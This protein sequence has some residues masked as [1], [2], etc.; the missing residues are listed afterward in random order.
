MAYVSISVEGGMFPSDLLDRMAAGADGLDG[1]RA[2]DFGLPRGARLTEEMQAAFAEMRQLRDMFHRRQSRATENLTT[3]TRRRWI[4]PLLDTL[5]YNELQVQRSNLTAGPKTFTISHLAAEDEHAPPVNIIAY[6][7]DL[8]A[9]QGGRGRAPHSQVQEYLNNGEAL[10]GLVTNGQKL[11]LLRDSATFSRP[12]YVEFDLDRMAEENLY[13]EF[14]LLYR[15]VHRTRLPV[16]SS[17]AHECYLEKYYRQGVEQGGRVKEKLRDG[18]EEALKTF[19]SALLAHPS[20]DQLREAIRSGR[21]DELGYYRQLLRLIYRLLFLLVAEER[22][23]LFDETTG[24]RDLQQIYVDHYSITALRDRVDRLG[25]EQRSGGRHSDLWQGLLTTFELFRHDDS[26]RKLGL[27]A[28]DGELFGPHGCR[29]IETATCDNGSLVS[30]IKALSWFEDTEGRGR[31]RRGV[32]RRVNY[33]GL[34]VE[35]LGSIYESL[36]DFAPAVSLEPPRFRL[37]TGSERKTTGSYY[38]PAELVRELVNSAL[39]PVIEDRLDAAVTPEA[40]EHALLDIKVLDPA[41]GSGH[42]L[43]A[44]A[45]RIAHELAKVRTRT[46]EPPPRAFGEALRDVIRN[47]VYAVDKNPLAVDLCKVALWM[48]S[49]QP[50]LPLSFL[51]HRVRLGDSLVGVFDLKVLED[52]IPDGAFKDV[53]GDDKAIAKAVRERNKKERTG[54]LS[55]G[56]RLDPDPLTGFA[57]EIG[58]FADIEERSAE[59][60]EVKAKLFEELRHGPTWYRY[61]VACDL[62]TAAFFTPLTKDTVDFVP[63]TAEVRKQLSTTSKAAPFI[64]G[65]A[66]ELQ[67]RLRFF[68][69]PLEFLDVFARRGFD[70]VLSNPPWEKF[71][72]KEQEFFHARAPEVAFLAGDQRK[73]AIAALETSDPHLFREWHD[74]QARIQH[75]V[76]FLKESGRFPDGAA[77]RQYL[78]AVFAEVLASLVGEPGYSGILCPTGIATDDSTKALFGKL[79]A[80]RIASL[81]DFENSQGLFE[82]VHRSYKFCLL[83]VRGRIDHGRPADF[84]FCSTSI[85][86]LREPARHFALTAD[87]FALFNPN[88]LTCPVFRS[89]KDSEIARKMYQRAGVFWKEARSTEP[90]NN[91]WGVAFQQMFNMTSDS[92]L[93]RSREELDREGFELQ[94]NVF[95]HGDGREYLPLYEA[96]LFHQYDHRFAT[97]EGASR[98]ELKSGNARE[99]TGVQRANPDTV[100]IPR[101]WVPAEEVTAKLDISS[102]D[103]TISSK[104]EARSSKLEARSSKLEARSSKLE[105]RS[106]KLEARSSKLE[107]RSSGDWRSGRSPDP[108]TNGPAFGVS[109]RHWLS[110]T[111]GRSPSSALANRFPKDHA[112]DGRTHNASGNSLPA[113]AQRLGDH[114]RGWLFCFRDIARA[115]DERTAI[116]CVVEGT[117]VSNKAPLIQ[118]DAL[119]ETGG[120]TEAAGSALVLAC[121]D[122]LVLD[123]AARFSVGGI[124]MNFFIV[125]QLPVLPPKAL[126]DEVLPGLTYAELVIPRVLELTYTAWDIEPFAR[127]LGYEGEPFPWDDER[128]HRLKS[129]LDAIFARLYHLDREDLEWILDAPY[130]SASFPGLKRKELAQFHEYRTQRYVLHAYDQLARGELPDLEGADPSVPE[131]GR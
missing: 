25:G 5:G 130:P 129:E 35:E 63:T 119:Q 52:G 83:T 131:Y 38:T 109:Y 44:A 49:Q 15:L 73:R 105:A 117:G 88:T 95:I 30:A 120:W 58:G 22:R 86:H 36:L 62:W 125:K 71:E 90:E 53:T 76:T 60:H 3:L 6:D 7:Q 51:D 127:D 85:D 32:M 99:M 50:G 116:A 64:V 101:Y 111:A 55:L 54:Q 128:R 12:T 75:V 79:A 121:M 34:N 1:Q 40:R 16:S 59:D 124:N 115:T 93:F 45:R 72:P 81:Y 70:C 103:N 126:L 24:A 106:S 112:S 46:E 29:E 92:G 67:Q 118:L 98:E 89:K 91:P 43:L 33:G 37:V 110:A 11:R 47:C 69:W 28:L 104:L 77:G 2:E 23:Q 8:D 97:F 10:W 102:G 61:K 18:V 65:Q 31:N 13:S 39:V 4:E 108:P 19:G 87:D 21:L 68:H 80:G 57:S 96:K 123:W 74:H 56:M 48:E 14:V 27:H 26:A 94:G 114:P 107:A 113:G 78:Y 9:G 20:S 84:A 82:G 100:V 17:D 122:S 66:A 41:A 42:F